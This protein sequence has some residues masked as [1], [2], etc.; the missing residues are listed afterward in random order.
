[1]THTIKIE[2]VGNDS[3]FHLLNLPSLIKSITNVFAK[4]TV[5][6]PTNIEYELSATS[7][8]RTQWTIRVMYR[9]SP[10]KILSKYLIRNNFDCQDW[11]LIQVEKVLTKHAGLP[12]T[13]TER[14]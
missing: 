8:E 14:K 7:P 6:T 9:S 1:M 11:A 12:E 3:N 10:K 4:N 2:I 5:K 13:A